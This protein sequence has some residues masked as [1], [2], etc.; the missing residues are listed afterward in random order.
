MPPS[1][2]AAPT[3]QDWLTLEGLKLAAEG[4]R[5]W[6]EFRLD[7]A[8][9]FY[10]L[11]GQVTFV[12][13]MGLQ[14]KGYSHDDSQ[15]GVGGAAAQLVTVRSNKVQQLARRQ[16]AMVVQTKPAFAPVPTNTSYKARAACT[17]TKKLLNYELDRRHLARSL[18]QTG[19]AAQY[20]AM[21]SHLRA[22]VRTIIHG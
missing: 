1:L 6:K 11:R 16:L 15:L 18:I 19:E 20:L 17:F 8:E 21:M 13:A 12:E 5:R 2:P 7:M 4:M 14:G 10:F 22:Q 9:S 3:D